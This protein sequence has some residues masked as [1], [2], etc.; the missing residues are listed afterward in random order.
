VNVRLRGARRAGGAVAGL[1][2]ASRYQVAT[3]WRTQPLLRA[4][5]RDHVH[6]NIVGG[7]LVEA[8]L[9]NDRPN[10][11]AL[12]CRLGVVP[13]GPRPGFAGLVG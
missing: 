10:L 9:W 5:E 12:H 7:L 2:T 3:A 8:H 1:V 6:A 4:R 13:A 11:S